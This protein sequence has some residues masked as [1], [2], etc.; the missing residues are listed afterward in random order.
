MDSTHI[1]YRH[2]YILLLTL[3]QYVEN[4]YYMILV[5]AQVAKIFI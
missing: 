3:M 1:G 4:R 2:V 5:L